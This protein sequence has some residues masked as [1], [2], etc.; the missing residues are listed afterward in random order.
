MTTD[1][2][3]Q[4]NGHEKATEKEK[5]AAQTDPESV[6]LTEP[7]ES[8]AAV[9]SKLA[10]L[11]S[12]SSSNSEDSEGLKKRETWTNKIDFLPA[13]IGFSVGLGNVWRFPY[14]CYKNGGGT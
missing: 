10:D 1:T 12:A 9:M 13:C 5:E 7:S 6:R 3:F 14:L 8:S 4:A 11:D 2:D